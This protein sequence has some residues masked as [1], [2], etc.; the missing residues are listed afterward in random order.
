[1]SSIEHVLC[2]ARS[3]IQA[4]AQSYNFLPIFRGTGTNFQLVFVFVAVSNEKFPST[5]PLSPQ[6]PSSPLLVT[7]LS[8]FSRARCSSFSCLAYHGHEYIGII[9]IR[10]R[11]LAMI[12]TCYDAQLDLPGPLSRQPFTDIPQSKLNAR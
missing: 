9:P 4:Q 12:V 2:K 10:L 8:V 5:S 6:L 7:H 3:S 1:M 11:H